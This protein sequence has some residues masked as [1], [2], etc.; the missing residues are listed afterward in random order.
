MYYI[1]QVYIYAAKTAPAGAETG[2]YSFVYVVL[3]RPWHNIRVSGISA[4]SAVRACLW[5]GVSVDVFLA[6]L[7]IIILVVYYHTKYCVIGKGFPCPLVKI[8]QFSLFFFLET[9]A[10]I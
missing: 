6:S 10:G 9:S 5:Y 3:R 7:G 8:E 1:L 4:L 2:N